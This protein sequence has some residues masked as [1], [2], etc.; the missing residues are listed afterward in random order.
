MRRVAGSRQLWRQESIVGSVF[1][2]SFA[3]RDG[4]LLPSITGHSV[5]HGRV[6]PH[7]RSARSLLLGHCSTVTFDA[8]I[9]GG[10][11][12]GAACAVAFAQAGMRVALVERRKSEAAPPPWRWATSSCW[13][14]RR[15]SWALT[16]Y[17]QT[18]WQQMAAKLPPEAEYTQRGTLWVA[19]DEDEMREIR[20]KHS[21]YGDCGIPCEVLDACSLAQ[22]EPALG[23]GLFGGLLVSQDVVVSPRSLRRL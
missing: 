11:I 7:P 10:G 13:M 12:V 21:V 14:T 17:S 19:S 4:A 5:Y 3:L 18:L 20:R 9:V 1:E 15:P 6:D 2:A 22:A 16:R 23:S 8:V